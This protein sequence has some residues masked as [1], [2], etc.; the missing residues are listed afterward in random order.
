MSD[1]ECEREE[2]MDDYAEA[3]DAAFRK[4]AEC[5]AEFKRAEKAHSEAYGPYH[6]AMTHFHHT[7]NVEKEA[8]EKLDAVLEDYA[9]VLISKPEEYKQ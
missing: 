3:L 2:A 4:V 6:D 7:R 5:A 1:D 8:K 9:S